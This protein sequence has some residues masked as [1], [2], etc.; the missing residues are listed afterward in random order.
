MSLN[1]HV[2]AGRRCF[3]LLD[4]WI[5]LGIRE[6]MRYMGTGQPSAGITQS[7]REIAGEKSQSWAGGLPTSFPD[8][9]HS[10]LLR[11]EA[12]IFVGRDDLNAVA[13]VITVPVI[14]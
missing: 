5:S 2:N 4:R 10:H 9:D 8:I 11:V 3:V 12:A 1:P 13:H 7:I 6:S 14:R